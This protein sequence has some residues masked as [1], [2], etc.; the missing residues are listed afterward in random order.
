MLLHARIF[1]VPL[2]CADLVN[3]H[4][5]ASFLRWSG[6][7]YFDY[8]RLLHAVTDGEVS[9]ASQHAEQ[10]GMVTSYHI[11]HINHTMAYKYI[12]HLLS[13]SS[14][15]F[16]KYHTQP[17]CQGTACALTASVPGQELEKRGIVEKQPFKRKLDSGPLL[18]RT[19]R[20]GEWGNMGNM[21]TV[22]LPSF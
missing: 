3:P 15:L 6:S 2:L 13:L 10:Q 1:L 18:V 12:V 9:L 14:S 21:G 22:M 16:F 5:A 7:N 20:T 8:M 17:I 11:H 19:A 4:Q